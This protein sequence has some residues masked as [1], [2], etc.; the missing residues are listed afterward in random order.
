[1]TK[2][3]LPEQNGTKE[4]CELPPLNHPKRSRFKKIFDK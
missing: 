2:L 1:L 4:F 3:A